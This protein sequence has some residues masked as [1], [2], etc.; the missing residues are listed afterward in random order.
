MYNLQPCHLLS[1]TL[2]S[3]SGLLVIPNPFQPCGQ[4]HWIERCLRD[5]PLKPNICNLDA[6][7]TRPGN[8]Q[9]WPT[10]DKSNLHPSC[11]D[12]QASNAANSS[13]VEE[14]YEVS[15]DIVRKLNAQHRK[16]P[17][18][19]DVTHDQDQS[20]LKDIASKTS[21]LNK[22]PP[23]KKRKLCDQA[24]LPAWLSRDT[25]LY[26][27][28]WVTLGYHYDWSSKEYSPQH[29]ST[30]PLELGQLSSFVMEAVG[31]SG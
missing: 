31:F 14:D 27:L 29:R 28:R 3:H 23:I 4:H 8:G 15:H 21:P 1:T 30:F 9:L 25:M 16:K 10:A 5:Y 11:I 6:H 20:S 7:M 22:K 13:C 17:Y 24:P 2:L 26:K 19:H 18:D 12:P